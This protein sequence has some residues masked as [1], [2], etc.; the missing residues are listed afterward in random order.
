[1]KIIKLILFF[2]TF[3]ISPVVA[4]NQ[5]SIEKLK[6]LTPKKE[7]TEL[8]LWLDESTPT[9]PF[10]IQIFQP[11]EDKIVIKNYY[12]DGSGG[13]AEAKKWEN[14][15]VHLGG[16]F[17]D[18]YRLNGDELEIWDK[19]GKIHNLKLVRFHKEFNENDL[20]IELKELASELNSFKNEQ[21]FRKYGFGRG[22]PYSNWNDEIGLIRKKIDKTNSKIPFPLKRAPIDL[23]IIAKG[24]MRDGETKENSSEL[25]TLIKTIESK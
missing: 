3:I 16:N 19:D 10:Y 7:V 20:R 9:I 15:K 14:G 17:G 24:Y 6:S 22:G 25:K 21:A 1:M 5:N 23:L 2:S 8:G 12:A 4:Q 11:N 13:K 18:H